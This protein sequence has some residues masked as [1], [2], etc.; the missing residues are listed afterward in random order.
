MRTFFLRQVRHDV[1]ALSR[2]Q[3][4]R[5]EGAQRRRLQRACARPTCTCEAP[6]CTTADTCRRGRR[7]EGT[8]GACMRR[9]GSCFRTRRCSSTCATASTSCC[10]CCAC[11]HGASRDDAPHVGVW[12]A[13]VQLHPR[14]SGATAQERVWVKSKRREFLLEGRAVQDLWRT[15]WAWC[16]PRIERI[17]GRKNGGNINWKRKRTASATP[18]TRD[19]KPCHLG[20]NCR[21]IRSPAQPP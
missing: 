13:N 3:H 12:R 4:Q 19:R 5:R 21:L 2:R 20:G 11:P 10:A 1:H 16:K 8:L 17:Q 14:R 6:L 15:L 9:I 7:S 18:R